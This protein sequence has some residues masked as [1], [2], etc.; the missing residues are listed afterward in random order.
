MTGK[1]QDL[2]SMVLVPKRG[3]KRHRDKLGN[4]LVKQ[5]YHSMIL[6]EGCAWQ[7][8]QQDARLWRKQ[9]QPGV[10]WG[11]WLVAILWVERTSEGMGLMEKED[12]VF[13]HCSIN[14]ISKYVAAPLCQLLAHVLDSSSWKSVHP[15][16]Q[17]WARCKR[18]TCDSI[19]RS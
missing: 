9:Q 1:W 3:G 11:F 7:Q 12:D 5:K 10:M 17:D 2:Q 4:S 19:S 18:Y 13:V 15:S 16:R 14:S 6:Q 8:C